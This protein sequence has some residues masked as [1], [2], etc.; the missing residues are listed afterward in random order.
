[1]TLNEFFPIDL[2]CLTS[3]EKIKEDIAF[4]LASYS[5]FEQFLVP[6]FLSLCKLGNI[7]SKLPKYAQWTY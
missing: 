4:L 5:N 2:G 7:L 1:M 3:A 6:L